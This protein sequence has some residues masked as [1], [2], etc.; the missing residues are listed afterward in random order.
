M[1]F[2]WLYSIVYRPLLWVASCLSFSSQK[3]K[4]GLDLRKKKKGKKPWL[5][6]EEGS[7][8]VWFHC[9]SG[10]Y[11]YAKPV[12][13]LIKQKNPNQKV[14]VTFFSP[15]VEP[16]LS[17][18]QDIDF[19]CPTP[20][21]T[22]SNWRE[23]INHHKPK[24]LLIARTDVWPMMVQQAEKLNVPRLLFSKTMD[25]SKNGYQKIVMR[26][27]LPLLSDIFCVTEEDRQNLFSEIRPFKNIHTAGDTRYDQCLYRLQNGRSVKPLNNFMKPVFIAGSTWSADEEALM[28]T[29][30]N[31]IKDVAFVVA[32]HEPSESHLKSLVSKLDKNGIDYQFYSKVNSWNSKGVLIIDQVGILADLYGWGQFAFIGGSMNRSV[33]SVMESLAQGLLTFVGPKHINN[34][35]AL[36]FKNEKLKGI[37][38]VQVVRTGEE[39]NQR[40]SE[41]LKTWTSN[42]QLELQMAVKKRSGA[43]Q[44]VLKWLEN[45]Q[46][47]QTLD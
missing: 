33:H 44:I 15:S 12:I 35:E 19:Y 30:K 34:R 20:W 4:K 45:N 47:D 32:P 31:H 42:H 17:K 5:D 14:L 22:A 28:P 2:F 10:E 11:E 21:D 36:V 1:I 9:A 39:L 3:L 27:L 43:S 25:S 40:F 6:F 8:P 7:Q 24:A 29:I 16:A 46:L 38:P 18:A 26:K 13:R 23:F 41:L 37:A